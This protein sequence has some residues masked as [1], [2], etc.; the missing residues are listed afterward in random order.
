MERCGTLLLAACLVGITGCKQTTELVTATVGNIIYGGLSEMGDTSR[1]ENERRAAAMFE[2]PTF[3]EN[4][5]RA[6]TDQFE[7]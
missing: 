3:G 6:V 1:P 4:F 5:G 7:D 2:G